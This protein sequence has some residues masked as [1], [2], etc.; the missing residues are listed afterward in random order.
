M[1][2]NIDVRD[3]GVI[4]MAHTSNIRPWWGIGN[5]ITD[6]TDPERTLNEAGIDFKYVVR[7]P[8]LQSPSGDRQSEF[9]RCIVVEDKEGKQKEVAA[10][11][12][13]WKPHQP[14]DIIEFYRKLSEKMELRLETAGSLCNQTKIWAMAKCQDGFKIIDDEYHPYVSFITG[15]TRATRLAGHSEAIVCHNTMQL[16]L[17]EGVTQKYTH[18]SVLNV[19]EAMDNVGVVSFNESIEQLH[20][21]STSHSLDARHYFEEILLG[22]N[23]IRKFPDW[24]GDKDSVQ[25]R[26]HL[27]NTDALYEA[28]K[29]SPGQNLRA[30]KGT[31]LG[32]FNAVT[33]WADHVRRNG[34]NGEQGRAN[35]IL[36]G[37]LGV[38]KKQ[39][40]DLALEAA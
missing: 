38:L 17:D 8:W 29:N 7:I 31:A 30:R 13:L 2:A 26:H 16:A 34:R 14:S 27:E 19:E 3:N 1:S 20:K 40:Y 24:Y 12:T 18:H 36:D 10:C 4:R 15:V 28:Y 25:Y 33:Y 37:A 32:A 11:G 9:A 35:S 22:V 21:L 5:T 23:R 39:A 6:P